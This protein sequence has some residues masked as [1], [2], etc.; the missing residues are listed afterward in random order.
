MSPSIL[1]LA[2]AEITGPTSTDVPL[3]GPTF[4]LEAASAIFGMIS[5][6][7]PTN[8]A[9][10][11][12]MH[13]WPAAPQLAPTS[14]FTTLS[15]SASG[16]TTAWFLAP[17]LHCA[18]LPFLPARWWMWA[19]AA[20]PPTKETAR[21]CSLSQRKFTVSCAPCTTLRTPGGRPLS[22]ASSASIMAVRGTRSEGLSRNVLPA[23]HAGGNI[24]KGIMAGKLKGAT[25]AHTPS[26]SR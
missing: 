19:P 9:T 20:L 13:R 11:R 12:A 5:L 8:T 1:L 26:G 18:L 2:A 15:G 21:M 3:P 10:L 6:E 17:R 25:P 14:W 24:H 16:S 4:N 7:L 23:V 22:V